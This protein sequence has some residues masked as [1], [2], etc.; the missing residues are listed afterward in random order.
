MTIIGFMGNAGSGKSCA[1]EYLVNNIP[2]TAEYSF[3]TPLKKACKELFLL[4][5]TQLYGTQEQKETGDPRWFGCSPRTMMQYLGTDLLRKQMSKI[6]PELGEGIF[7]HSA[8]LWCDEYLSENHHLHIVISDVRFQNEVDFIHEQGGIVIKIN[9]DD[10]SSNGADHISEL[11]VNDI[12][13][14]DYMIDNNGTIIDYYKKIRDI[15]SK[16]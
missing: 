3:A 15:I 16:I 5:D 11:S 13:D 7:I 6:I 12:D 9:R 1:A 10:R 8:R 14:Y 2:G 4:S